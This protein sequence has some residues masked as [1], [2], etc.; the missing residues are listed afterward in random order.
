[1]Q[2]TRANSAET[3]VSNDL[4]ANL[5]LEERPNP[6]LYQTEEEEALVNSTA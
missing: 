3:L 4:L 1:M 5:T 6:T 2:K